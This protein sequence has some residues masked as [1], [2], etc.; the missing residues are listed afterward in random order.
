MNAIYFVLLGTVKVYDNTPES[1]NLLKKMLSHSFENKTA[2]KKEAHTEKKTFRCI[3]DNV[4]KEIQDTIINHDK[5]NG[6][7]KAVSTLEYGDSFGC[8][9]FSK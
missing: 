9:F 2:Q 4:M 6:L 7:L 5:N 1:L 3:D 8:N